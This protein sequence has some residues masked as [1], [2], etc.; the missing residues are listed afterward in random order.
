M[1]IKKEKNIYFFLSQMQLFE[2][3]IHGAKTVEIKKYTRQLFMI[4]SIAIP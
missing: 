4:I 2:S 1:L 3:H